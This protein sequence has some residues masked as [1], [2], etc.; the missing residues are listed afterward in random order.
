MLS[1]LA[2]SRRSQP[3]RKGMATRKPGAALRSM[4]RGMS[5]YGQHPLHAQRQLAKSYSARRKKRGL[6]SM[7]RTYR[8]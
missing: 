5:A 3:Y 8:Y 2:S 6:A 1:Y 4:K 7:A